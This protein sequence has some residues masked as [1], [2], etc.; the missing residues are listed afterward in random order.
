MV[1]IWGCQARIAQLEADN[2]WLTVIVAS[3][4]VIVTTLAIMLLKSR[5]QQATAPPT[6]RQQVPR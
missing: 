2:Q 4:T 5:W 3:L 6:A 1:A